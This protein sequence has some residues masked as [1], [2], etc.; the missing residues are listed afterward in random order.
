MQITI[1]SGK[2]GTGK[3][4][5]ATSIFLSHDN[6]QLLD[7]D[8]DEPN[9]FLFLDF[10]Y[11]EVGKAQVL[12]PEI[13]NT[14]CT[15]CGIC[16]DNC[17]YNSLIN[18]PGQVV[19]FEKICHGC[20]LCSFLCP[21][22]AITEKPRTLGKI[23]FGKKKELTF[24]YGELIVGEEL[25]TP[26]IMKLKEYVQQEKELVIID[27]PPG[28]ACPMV[29]AVIDSDFVIVVAEPTPFGLSDMQIVVE[30]LRRLKKKFG[31]IINKDGIGNDELENY[32]KE[33]GI[34]VLMKIPFDMKIAQN[35]SVGKTLLQASSNW[36]S[37]FRE[38]IDKIRGVVYNE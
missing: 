26:V 28:S 23:F 38:L 2:G 13:D 14:K 20:G 32:C 34:H 1:A 7:A 9:C 24:H 36:K 4:I 33:E 5:I 21:E 17:E 22:N 18:L 30:T 11:K 3:T 8:V 19:V 29:E 10:D 25:S 31:V 27:S 15:H 37:Q 35:Y 16:S 12:V 6:A